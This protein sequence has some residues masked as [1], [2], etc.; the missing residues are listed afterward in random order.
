MIDVAYVLKDNNWI[1][2]P[3]RV[4]PLMDDG[5]KNFYR[6]KVRLKVIK[7]WFLKIFTKEQWVNGVNEPVL[8][9]PY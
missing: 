8:F 4:V 2:V 6:N 7:P 5:S 1:S 9:Y 3:A